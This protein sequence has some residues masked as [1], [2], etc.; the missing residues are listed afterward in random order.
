MK[1]KKEHFVPLSTQAVAIL[2]EAQ[3]LTGGGRYVF[4]GQRTP[5]RPMSENTLNGALRRLGYSGE[6]MT[7]HGFRALASTLLNESGKWSPDAIE[8]AQSRGVAGEVRGIY[9]RG[10]YWPERVEMAQWWSDHLDGLREGGKVVPFSRT[11]NG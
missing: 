6:E 10:Q 7:S 5:K 3:G 4:P 8:R 9:N 1:M 11:G 2:K